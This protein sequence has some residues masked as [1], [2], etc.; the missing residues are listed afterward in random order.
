MAK[1]QFVLIKKGKGLINGVNPID[2]SNLLELE[3]SNDNSNSQETDPTVP[4]AVKNITGSQIANWDSAYNWGNHASKGYL[5][6]QEEPNPHVGG[7]V[8]NINLIFREGDYYGWD[9]ITPID[10]ATFN[11]SAIRIGGYA[12][13]RINTTSEPTVTYS[14][15]GSATITKLSGATFAANTTMELII[16]CV[17]SGNYNKINYFFLPIE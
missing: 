8:G 10:Q 15:S 9:Q 17:A 16:E 1:R 3:S 2:K 5:T 7:S 14:G 4:A 12:R 6:S 11:V 13:I